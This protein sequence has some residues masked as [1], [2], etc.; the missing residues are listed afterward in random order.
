[1][2]PN[3]FCIKKYKKNHDKEFNRNSPKEFYFNINSIYLNQMNRDFK[4]IYINKFKKNRK[5]N[6][7]D[8]IL[9]RKFK[10]NNS[11]FELLS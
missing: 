4:N 1:L 10:I 2:N 7:F 6:L 11:D 9:E 8:K 3:D 5:K